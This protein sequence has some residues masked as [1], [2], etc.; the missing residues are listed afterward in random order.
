MTKNKFKN[1]QLKLKVEVNLAL[2]LVLALVSLTWLPGVASAQIPGVT[3]L[4]G[5][6]C[7][8][9]V[10]CNS[11]PYKIRVTLDQN[12]FNTSDSYLVKVER[13]D[14]KSADWQLQVESLPAPRTSATPVKFK[15]DFENGTTT[16]RAAKIDFPISGAWFVH[17]T[18]KG[19]AGTGE[20][21]LPVQVAAPPKLDDWLAWVIGLS[22]LL[23][24]AGFAIGQWRQVVQ[25][26]KAEQEAAPA[27]PTTSEQEAVV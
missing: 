6:E 23:G 5:V 7:Q 27:T 26:K 19:S 9:G 24:I 20:F 21:R 3:R 4:P 18:L 14:G 1:I 2:A 11:G 12:S 13:L 15:G 10:E 8:V 17:L 22:P 25:R 16:T